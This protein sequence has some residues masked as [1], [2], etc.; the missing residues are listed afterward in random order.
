MNT[1][2]V[3]ILLILLGIFHGANGLTMLVAPDYWYASVPGVTATGPMNHHFLT[4][5]GLAF[6]AS[7]IGLLMALRTGRTAATLALAGATWP[8]LHGLFHLWEWIAD[9][10][11]ANPQ[12]IVSDAVAVMAVSFAG[13][14]LAW[15]WAHREGVV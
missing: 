13:F 11:P 7:A 8:A 10:I 15:V 9:G 3:R 6:I 12:Q 2:S 14:W 4:D 5:I 1:K